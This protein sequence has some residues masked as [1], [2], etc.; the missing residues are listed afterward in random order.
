MEGGAFSWE[1]IL[2]DPKASRGCNSAAPCHKMED[3]ICF[4]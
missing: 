1:T 2:Q 4:Y 3:F